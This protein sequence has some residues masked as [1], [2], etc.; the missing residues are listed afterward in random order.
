MFHD[1]VRL[2]YPEER[3]G[4]LFCTAEMSL[5]IQAASKIGFETEGVSISLCALYIKVG[6]LKLFSFFFYLN[7]LWIGTAIDIETAS[8]L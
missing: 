6:I 4:W 7:S 5:L 1:G 2:L 3:W 8:T